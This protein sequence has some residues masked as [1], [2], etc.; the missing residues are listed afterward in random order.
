MTPAMPTDI[1]TVFVTA[2][3]AG[4]AARITRTVVE[5]GLAACGNVVP[6][7]VSI[8]RWEGAIER[9]EEVLIILKTSVAAVE[10]LRER[11]VELHP[12]DVPE[13]LALAVDSGHAPYLGWVADETMRGA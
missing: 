1:R 3:D 6:N 7:V 8:F 9:A 2:P 13:V 10:A 11:V 5:E 4:V 12:Y